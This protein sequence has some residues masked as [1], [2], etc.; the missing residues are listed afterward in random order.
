MNRLLALGLTLA[1]MLGSAVLSGACGDSDDSSPMS[2][3]EYFTQLEVISNGLSD[4]NEEAF[5]TLNE[6]SDVEELKEAFASLPR[7]MQEFLTSF[8]NLAPPEEVAAEHADTEEDGQALLNLLE[9][10]NG[11]V[12]ETTDVDSFVATAGNDELDALNRAFVAHCPLLEGIATDNAI[13][14]DL[15]CPE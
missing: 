9:E 8:E 14:V 7:T 12:Q 3:D 6:S 4:S 10:V 11:D 1:L 15:G 2:L 13:D 5:T